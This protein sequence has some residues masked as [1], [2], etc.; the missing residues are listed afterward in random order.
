MSNQS[1]FFG[2]QQFPPCALC[3]RCEKYCR[4]WH[5]LPQ[6]KSEII[7]PKSTIPP[8]ALCPRC[9]KFR[10]R[11]R[12]LTQMKAS[13]FQISFPLR[14]CE[15]KPPADCADHRRRKPKSTIPLCALCPQCEKFRHRWHRLPQMKSEIN[16]SSVCS[17]S[18]VREKT[19]RGLRR[20]S[21]MKSGQFQIQSSNL[22]PS[23][24]L[25][26]NSSRGLRR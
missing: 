19:S 11:W 10:H 6:M 23:A 9:G 22:F 18:S 25:R 24:P 21:Q 15:K 2:N 4:R 20:S 26:E 13:Q 5:R 16:N 17:V 3:P 8:C 14:L 12:R 7:P 1:S